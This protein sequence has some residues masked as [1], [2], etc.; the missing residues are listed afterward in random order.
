MDHVDA[1]H[2]IRG[3]D[4]PRLAADIQ[5][6]RR[7][8]IGQARMRGPRGDRRARGGFRIAWLPGQSR[9][10]C[11]EVHGMLAGAAGNFQYR[12]AGGQHFAQYRKDRLAVALGGGRHA[13]CIG[14]LGGAG[15][16]GMLSG[17]RVGEVHHWTPPP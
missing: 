1:D 16:D 5:R 12:A 8:H 10:R 4:A 7:A 2:R 14:V 11:R 13:A 9:Q 17:G 6:Q 15:H 3:V